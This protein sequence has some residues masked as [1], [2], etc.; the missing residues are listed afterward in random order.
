MVLISTLN[1]WQDNILSTSLLSSTIFYIFPGLEFLL[2]N[3]TI[4]TDGSGRVLITDSN[5]TGP[6]A[7]ICQSSSLGGDRE[8]YLDPE[9]ENPTSTAE[10]ERIHGNNFRGWTRKRNE[11][12]T[13]DILQIVR[14]KRVSDTAVEGRFTCKI[15]QDKDSP[16]GLLILHPSKCNV[17]EAASLCLLYNT[18]HALSWHH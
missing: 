9:D 18:L 17:G 4:P 10:A 14:L 7:L 6:G 16:R 2:N 12:P 8:W 5:F 15:P 13:R 11:N 3:I 1:G